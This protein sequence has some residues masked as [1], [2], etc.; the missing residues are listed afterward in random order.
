MS[1]PKDFILV[2][3]GKDWRVKM[4]SS[5]TFAKLHS[6]STEGVTLPTKREMHFDKNQF[7]HNVFFHECLHCLVTE[8]NTGSSD[9]TAGQMEE[10]CAEILYEHYFDMGTWFDKVASYYRMKK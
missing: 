10:L 3:K 9:L 4:L 7:S 5:S 1:R 6:L 2:I 8:S